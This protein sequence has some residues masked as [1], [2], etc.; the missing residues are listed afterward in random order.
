MLE[1][2]HSPVGA[3]ETSSK[4]T[5]AK[6]KAKVKRKKADGNWGDKCMYAEL[7]EMTEDE[8]W[9][10][11][12]AGAHD[13]LPKDLE[14]GWVAVAPVPVGKRC[15]AITYQTSGPAGAGPLKYMASCVLFLTVLV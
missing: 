6:R 12:T 5:K 11:S 9:S 13:G 2:T 14:S 10:G 4:S 3:S 8:P 15:I 7:L 1:T